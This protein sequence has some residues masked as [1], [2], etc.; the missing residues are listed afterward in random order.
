MLKK[1]Y[2]DRIKTLVTDY[3]KFHNFS[4]KNYEK[5]VEFSSI[6]EEIKNDIKNI[7]EDDDTEPNK[8]YI[9]INEK[10]EY[11][12]KVS[13]NMVKIQKSVIDKKNKLDKEKSILIETCLDDHK[14]LTEKDVLKIFSKI[15]KEKGSM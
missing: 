10:L 12:E 6:L 14:N 2:I 5:I 9:L 13:N 4:L 15:S 8:K 7:T 3:D 11:I 1:I